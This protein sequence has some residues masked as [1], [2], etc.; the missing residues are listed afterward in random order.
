ME[1][2]SI[3]TLQ[4]S[5]KKPIKLQIKRIESGVT[6]LDF[7]YALKI[8]PTKL[9]LIENGHIKAEWW[10]KEYSAEIL[11]VPFEDLWGGN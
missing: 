4:P 6:A 3:R 10:I 1:S 9:S 7:A 2:L 8:N 11:G 5:K